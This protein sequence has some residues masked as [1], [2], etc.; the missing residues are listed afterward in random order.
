MDKVLKL[1]DLYIGG[2]KACEILNKLNDLLYFTSFG[3]G[4]NPVQNRVLWKIYYL[5]QLEM[6]L[7]VVPDE[8]DLF[9]TKDKIIEKTVADLERFVGYIYRDKILEFHRWWQQMKEFEQLKGKG[10]VRL[11]RT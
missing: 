2:T 4:G 1:N 3:I 11:V 10:N 8:E 5:A 9:L 7:P 6:D